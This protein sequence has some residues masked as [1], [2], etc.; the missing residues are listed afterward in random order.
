MRTETKKKIIGDKRHKLLIG[1]CGGLTGVYLAKCFRKLGGFDIW[2]SDANETSVGKFFVDKMVCL[3][4]SDQTD[5]IDRLL[6]TFHDEQIDFYIPTHST[7][8]YAVAKNEQYIREKSDVQFIISPIE[9]YDALTDKEI[10]YSNLKRIEVPT[11]KIYRRC[12]DVPNGNY[13][14]YKKKIG[15]GSVDCGVLKNMDEI[16]TVMNVRKEDYLFCEYIEGDTYTVDCL[17]SEDG[18]LL[19]YNQRMRD[20]CIGGAVSITTNSNLINILPYLEKIAKY[21][22]MKGTVNFQYILNNGYP[23]FIDVNLRYAS[24]GLPLS[25]ASGVNVPLA[26]KKMFLGEKIYKNEFMSDFS[27][28]RMYRYYEEIIDENPIRF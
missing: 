10:A 3:P 27:D 18:E 4:K 7:E 6:R 17:F 26:M 2:G 11:P 25:V 12:E 14:F 8:M 1:S 5:F 21:W 22:K 20:K 28:R 9:T 19:G 23:Y 24:G 15:S 16:S 13:V